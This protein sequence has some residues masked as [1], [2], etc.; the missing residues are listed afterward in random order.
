MRTGSFQQN[1]AQASM[2]MTQVQIEAELKELW[3]RARV[4]LAKTGGETVQEQRDKCKYCW[5]DATQVLF[6]NDT[7]MELSCYPCQARLED[8]DKDYVTKE[9][10]FS[11]TIYV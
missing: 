10:A 4:L 9:L 11:T 2:T 7:S 5:N 8:G 1:Q 3:T 6:F